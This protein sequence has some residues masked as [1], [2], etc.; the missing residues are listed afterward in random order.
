[1][2]QIATARMFPRGGPRRTATPRTLRVVQG[3]PDGNAL[4]VAA[5]VLVL[6]VGLVVVLLL[7]TWMAQGAFTLT[8]LQA[9]ADELAAQQATLQ[10][11]LDQE[12]SPAQLA[13]R[14]LDQGMVPAST[15]A[16]L[17]LSDGAIVGVA[18]PAAADQGFTV[19]TQ[20]APVPPVADTSSAA[21]AVKVPE[22]GTTVTTEGS[23][24]RTTV[25]TVNGASVETT[26]T[27][28]DAATG[29]STSSTTRAAA[30]A[31][32]PAR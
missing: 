8:K 18:E 21:E 10:E 12:S 24:T 31:A 5:C 15:A 23:I 17:R 27:S 19:V 26:V 28:V 6:T 4:L 7:N 13:R 32:Q 9:R 16:F 29:I 11:A 3:V 22:S 20:A 2:S 25:V 1:M 30:T 14:A